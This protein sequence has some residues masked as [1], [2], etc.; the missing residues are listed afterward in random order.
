MKKS[1]THHGGAEKNKKIY[2]KGREGVSERQYRESRYP[3]AAVVM[4]IPLAA[5]FLE[6]HAFQQAGAVSIY[7]FRCKRSLLSMDLEA[8]F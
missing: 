4:K 6:D 1:K 8:A 2:R 7:L 5:F 3:E